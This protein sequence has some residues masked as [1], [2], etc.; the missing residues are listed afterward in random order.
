MIVIKKRRGKKIKKL[1][2]NQLIVP[3][4]AGLLLKYDCHINVEVCSTVKSVQ[5]LF[6]YVYKGNDR[7]MIRL[8]AKKENVR[9]AVDEIK[10]YVD[11]RFISA[12]EAFWKLS[13]FFMHGRYPSVLPLDVHLDKKQF[14]LYPKNDLDGT[15]AAC[16][17]A[18]RTKLTA[19]FENNA[20][21][22][23]N[24]LTGKTGNLVE[25]SGPK[26]FYH[27]YPRYYTWNTDKKI[28]KR[29]V[30]GQWQIGRM[31]SAF[32][33]QGERWFLRILLNHVKGATSFQDL[34]CY[35]NETYDTFKKTCAARELLMDDKEWDKALH[36]ASRI[37]TGQ[38]F[39]RFFVMILKENHPVEPL[40]LWHKFKDHMIT[41]IWY[42][43]KIKHRISSNNIPS[44]IKK[45]LYNTALFQICDILE[46]YNI[47][48]I[49]HDLIKP[50]KTECIQSQCKEI[51]YETSFDQNECKKIYD[52][53]IAK[54]KNNNEQQ[55]VFEQIMSAVYNDDDANNSKK[56]FFLD[57]PGGT[58]CI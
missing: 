58:V 41:D 20:K 33:S 17:K 25:P 18:K 24:P 8:R 15:K 16:D 22:L 10:N 12:P 19:W 39:R 37:Q 4:N 1:I 46:S 50:N 54:I 7:A 28:W 11:S 49:D 36:E 27:Q 29:R 42:E 21:E 52:N 6:K 45:L 23:E 48:P 53:N 32:P 9:V 40:K 5:Y 26:L 51:Q 55:N 31:H 56:V 47:F 43:Y 57:A 38:Q 2:T 13:E 3:Y 14:V 34:L 35:E 30:N 44:N